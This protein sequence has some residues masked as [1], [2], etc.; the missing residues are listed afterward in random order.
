MPIES[1]PSLLTRTPHRLFRWLPYLRLL[2]ESEYWGQTQR[3]RELTMIT[4]LIIAI[5][6]AALLI[7][8][9]SGCNTVRGAGE[10]IESIGAAV[11]G[12]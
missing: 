2:T 7:A 10:D 12:S 5:F 1:K 6:S 9:M 3:E 4:R 11:S 8:S